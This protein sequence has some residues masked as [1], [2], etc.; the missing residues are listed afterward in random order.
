MGDLIALPPLPEAPQPVIHRG[1]A[2]P[3]DVVVDPLDHHH[4]LALTVDFRKDT[5]ADL[6]Y[7][8]APIAP[9]ILNENYPRRCG[10]GYPAY[11]L[12][13]VQD[14]VYAGP[15]ERERPSVYVKVTSQLK[16][17]SIRQVNIRTLSLTWS[18]HVAIC[19]YTAI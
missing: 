5:D 8:R 1:V 14:G 15:V 13:K 9:I 7:A 11:V 3:P 16:A 19:L 17:I 4:R 10:I 6:A 2:G 12:T 18:P